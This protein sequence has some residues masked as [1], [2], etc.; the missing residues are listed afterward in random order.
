MKYR[1]ENCGGELR[2]DPVSGKLKCDYCASEF[3]ADTYGNQP[4]QPVKLPDLPTEQNP[5]PEAE[6]PFV[7]DVRAQDFGF[8]TSTDDSTDDAQDLVLYTCPNCGA[9]VVTDKDTVATACVYCQTPMVMENKM[10]GTFAPSQIIPFEIDASRIGEIYEEYIQNKPFYP[11]EYSKANV[12]EKIKSIYLP[13]WLYDM[14]LH[15]DLRATGEHTVTY[16]RGRWII[17]DHSVFDLMREGKMEFS[18]VP[19]IADNKTPKDA[20][21][22]L[23][24][25]HYEKLRDFAPGYLPGY[26]A[27]RYDIDEKKASAPAVQRAQNTLNH[28]MTSTLGG[29]EG[30]R[31][32]GGHMDVDKAQA[33]YTLLPAYL[34]FMDFDNDADKL[35]AI[36]GQ[37]GKIVGNIPV[38]KKKKNR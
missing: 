18:K 34:L 14:K 22:A 17:T 13:F 12:I 21:D 16:S 26:L 11:D 20:M 36:N 32:L 8:V 30:L 3:D 29:Y 1:C 25:Y 15:G 4:D 6:E 9:E 10:T 33:Q 31:V 35:I 24:P 37:T 28:A 38:D 5:A 19:V 2:F 27:S 7:E 23:E